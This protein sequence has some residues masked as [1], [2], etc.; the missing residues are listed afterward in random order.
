MEPEPGAST[1]AMPELTLNAPAASVEAMTAVIEA[2]LARIEATT[3]EGSKKRPLPEPASGDVSDS[4][5]GPAIASGSS[6]VM[7]D[8]AGLK[9]L[10]SC[11]E[12]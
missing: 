7:S 11:M 12:A 8:E 3:Q 10:G 4:E 1:P 5:S 2:F 6:S 9:E